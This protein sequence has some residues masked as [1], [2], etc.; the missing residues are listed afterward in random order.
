MNKQWAMKWV[1]VLAMAGLMGC[2]VT[3]CAWSIGSDGKTEIRPTKGQELTDLKKAL[4]HG[5]ITDE[6]YH[7]Q[8]ARLLAK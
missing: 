5:A 6:E 2:L 7:A 3:G 8:K 4:D 1:S